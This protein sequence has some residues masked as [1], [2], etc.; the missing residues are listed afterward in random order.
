MAIHAAAGEM[1]RQKAE[2]EVR[3]GGEALRVGIKEEDRQRERGKFERQL[4][5]A[6]GGD[7]EQRG[8]RDRENPSEPERQVAGG[9]RAVCRAGISAVEFDVGNA[10]HRHGGGAGADHGDDDPED[11]TP[12]W[13]AADGAGGEQ[14]ADQRDREREDGVLEFDHFEHDARMR[15]SVHT[16]IQLVT[17]VTEGHEEKNHL[18]RSLWPFRKSHFSVANSFRPSSGT[19]FSARQSDLREDSVAELLD[20][21][22]DRFRLVVERRHG[23]H[24]GGAGVVNAQ[25]V[26]KMDAVERCFAQAEDERTAFLQAD[27][28]GAGEEVV[29]DTAGDRAERASRA[30]GDHHGVDGG[31]AGG[32]ASADVLVRQVLDF[33][34][35][36]AGEERRQFLAVGGD[37]SE[38]RG[39]QPQARI[40]SDQE[41]VG[42]AAVGVEQAQ[43]ALRVN[44]AACAGDCRR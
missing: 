27:V 7:D 12:R 25:H 19:D 44:R 20:R 21:V 15:D 26:F 5:Q 3:P 9:E 4:V 30:R 16:K 41:H 22:R 34:R 1:P 37:G 31:A 28:G 23:G 39:E 29:R 40:G 13:E 2:D 11:L 10:V 33:F 17:R 36:A 18:F 42:Y 38:F 43:Q 35:R 6:P 32:D 24:D 14:R 8:G